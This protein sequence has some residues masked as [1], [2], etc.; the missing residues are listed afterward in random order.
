MKN[1][2]AHKYYGPQRIRNNEETRREE[3]AA[4][5]IAIKRDGV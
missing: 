2:P 1:L 5:M 4:S 3:R